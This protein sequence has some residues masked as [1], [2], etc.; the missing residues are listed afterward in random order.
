MLKPSADKLTEH[1]H[2]GGALQGSVWKPSALLGS[3]L[4]R[5]GEW[6]E[7]NLDLHFPI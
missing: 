7:T 1:R 3:H 5:R 6:S 4:E 2:D